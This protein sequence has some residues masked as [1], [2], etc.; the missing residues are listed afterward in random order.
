MKKIFIITLLILSNWAI[1][2]AAKTGIKFEPRIADFGI[3]NDDEIKTIKILMINE[4]QV[5]YTINE[6]SFIE[7]EF[8]KSDLPE[9]FILKP[10]EKKSFAIMLDPELAAPGEF[11]SKMLFKIDTIEKVAL[12]ITGIIE[13]TEQEPFS[14]TLRLPEMAVDLGKEFNFPIIISSIEYNNNKIDGFSGKLVYNAS[15]LAPLNYNNDDKLSYGKRTTKIEKKLPTKL[16]VAGDTLFI[17]PMITALGNAV[18]SKIILDDVSF[19]YL[20]KEIDTELEIS[21]GVIYLKGL[22]FQDSVPRLVSKISSIYNISPPPNPVE[23]DFSLTVTY[24]GKVYL[25]IYT[26]HGAVVID[27][28]QELPVKTEKGTEEVFVP[29]NIFG[30]YGAYI[31]RLS[32][33]DEFVSRM[34]IVK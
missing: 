6:Y 24:T 29:R 33:K 3:V 9:K 34:I 15:V 23:N 22:I 12:Y 28:S 32:A 14:I 26:I 8:L 17:L 16:L 20:G 11:E 1:N 5:S 18:S 30:S 25:K 19:Y 2:T 7:G 31:I 27:F 4:A 21:N 13:E 10:G